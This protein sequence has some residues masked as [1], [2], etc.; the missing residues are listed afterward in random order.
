MAERLRE[1]LD[2]QAVPGW[3]LRPIPP[4][5]TPLHALVGPLLTMPTGRQFYNLLDR[6]GF[7][8]VEEVV[9]TPDD[10]LRLFRQCGPKM[11]AAIRLV[12]RD[13]GWD[14]P[15]YDRP[16]PAGLVPERQVHIVGRLSEAQRL[17]YREFA[18]MLARSSMPIS[19]LDKIIESLNAE[20]V[21]PADPLV[22]LLL[23][24]AREAEI[25][26]YYLDMHS[27]P[28]ASS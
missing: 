20:T 1:L 15:V 17:R 19:A 3:E 2:G 28:P 22:C 11:V 18:G 5:L 16:S 12:L 14:P 27:Q 8:T 6:E 13:L 4:G 7:A 21:P 23:E 25:A 9:A 26:R 24:T 10:C